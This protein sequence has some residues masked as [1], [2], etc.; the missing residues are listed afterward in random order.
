MQSQMSFPAPPTPLPPHR[1]VTP[2]LAAD[3]ASGPPT[4][5][6]PPLA[7]GAPAAA[8]PTASAEAPPSLPSS[9]GGSSPTTSWPKVAR[10][11]RAAGTTSKTSAG[12]DE[13]S[14]SFRSRN[15]FQ[16]SKLFFLRSEPSPRSSVKEGDS[17]LYKILVIGDVHTGKSAVIRRF[18]HDFYSQDYR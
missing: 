3:G 10:R 17:R 14:C 6:T 5:P 15:S 1:N 13:E 11:S 4:T 7:A 12:C 16:A 9:G 2:I 18:V 8:A